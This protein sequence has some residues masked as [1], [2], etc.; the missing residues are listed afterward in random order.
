MP[1]EMLC[2]EPTK[3]GVVGLRPVRIKVQAVTTNLPSVVFD[4][5]DKFAA[6]RLF[7]EL[8]CHEETGKPRR[9][10][11]YRVE[12]M[13]HE[14]TGSGGNAFDFRKKRDL[15]I[16]PLHEFDKLDQ[17][18]ETVLERK[19]LVPEESFVPPLGTNADRG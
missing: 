6:Y 15:V 10:I 11:V 19:P 17:L 18:L 3:P 2:Y 5:R 4:R 9:Y 13:A 1:K 7:A 8:R 14:Q 12:F 16:L